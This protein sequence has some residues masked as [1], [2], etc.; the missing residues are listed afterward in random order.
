MDKLVCPCSRSDTVAALH[1][2]EEKMAKHEEIFLPDD[3]YYDRKDHLWAKVEGG[4]V[5]VGLDMFGQKAAGTAAYIKI[6][7]VGKTV[8]KARAF[9]SLEAGKYIGP[10]KAPVTGKIVEINQEVIADPR[11]VNTDP[12]GK[13]WFVIIE[14]ANFSN[15]IH[16]LVHGAE[17]IQA[18]LDAEYKEYMEKG[19]FAEK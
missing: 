8:Q 9:G 16:D 17:N 5:R 10:L 6:L 15:D 1:K 19:L 13:G 2:L 18:W 14:P 7:P 4:Q 12:Y 11:L 3:L